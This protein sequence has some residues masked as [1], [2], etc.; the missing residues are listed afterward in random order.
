M[1][2]ARYLELDSR[3]RDRNRWPKPSEFEIPISQ[4]GSKNHTNALDPVS[5][6]ADLASWTANTFTATTTAGP[7]ITVQI[8][9]TTPPTIGATGNTTVIIVE[10]RCGHLQLLKDYYN[11]AILSSN[12]DTTSRVR[13]VG[14]KFLGQNGV[15]PPG[16]RDR[17]QIHVV[18]TFTT[19]AAV[20][21]PGSA[22]TITD[23]TDLT[24][25]TPYIFIPGP[26]LGNNILVNRVIYNHNLDQ[27]RPFGTYDSVTSLVNI[28]TSGS[29]T[30]TRYQGPLTGW[31]N[32]D[33]YSIRAHT[34]AVGNI[35][36]N[37]DPQYNHDTKTAFNFLAPSSYPSDSLIGWFLEHLEPPDLS[38]ALTA[39]GGS[40]T[41]VQLAIP[42]VNPS[43]GPAAYVGLNDFYVGASIR[44]I[45][46]GAGSLASG[47]IRKII[48]YDVVTNTATVDLAF[49][50]AIVL[51][52]TYSIIYAPSS[53]IFKQNEAR[54]ITKWVNYGAAAL[55]G[56]SNT[57][58]FP[59]SASNVNGYYSNLFIVMTGTGDIR[60]I[61]SYTVTTVGNVTTR[62]ATLNPSSTNF[63]IAVGP[64]DT[65]TITSGN[66]QP[67]NGS[68]NQ[69]SVGGIVTKKFA[70]LPYTKD[71]LVPFSY[72]GSMVSQQ[73]MVC[74]ELE[75]LNLIL[76]N[77]TLGTAFGS[78]ISFYQYVYVE[79]QNVSA[80]GAGLTNI[81]YSNN[82]NS[83]KM[84]FRCPIKDV[85][86][87]VNSTFIKIDGNGMKQTIKFKPNDT[88]KFSVHMSTGE[89][90][91]TLIPEIFGPNDPDP[92]TQISACFKMTRL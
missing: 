10:A 28:I 27:S 33:T 43:P 57:V 2:S 56:S 83:S 46:A 16:A 48:S 11:G 75:L 54:K 15:V 51:G 65:F 21:T 70:L 9:G 39:Q 72:S 29:S 40:T 92:I 69:L 53:Y 84:L 82:P 49:S 87:P 14:Y 86:N 77:N 90:F 91:E 67:F 79:L 22:F 24:V 35:I 66:T 38:P 71:N 60:L 32:N 36:L 31:S 78:L 88:L 3:F 52:D 61:G 50:S 1:S 81:I 76:P 44:I 73:E 85:P 62:V 20:T 17:A 13:I 74:Y 12:L 42:G 19:L 64:G 55:N 4:T 8:S 45:T 7:T 30:A 25:Q 23:P 63:S 18:G 34:P 5:D 6:A 68:I 80:S 58:V 41:T 89:L 59:P 37:G 26:T 47:E